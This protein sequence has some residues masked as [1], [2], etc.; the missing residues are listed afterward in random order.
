MIKD[1]QPFR[2]EAT[3]EELIAEFADGGNRM[4]AFLALY[5]RGATALPAVRTGLQHANWHI[6]HW[7]AILADNFADA[8]TLQ[9][10]VP[11]LRDPRTEVRVWAVHSLACERCKDGANP[12]DAIPLLLD[13]IEQDAHIKV[14]RQAV[15]MLAHHRTPDPRVLPVF[16]KILAQDDDRKLRLHA[17]HGLRRY[18][19]A[20][21]SQRPGAV[22]R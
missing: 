6:R 3:S 20:V 4:A 15:A 13:R 12:V 21:T 2:P 1:A 11:L 9:A 18:A 19:A 16:E 14:R 22:R 10:L 5:A 7:S 8:E 17:E